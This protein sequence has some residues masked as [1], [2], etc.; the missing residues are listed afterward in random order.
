MEGGGGEKR[1][2][3]EKKERAMLEPDKPFVHQ[4]GLFSLL[5]DK[6]WASFI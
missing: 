5:F 2:M 3:K 4:R 6:H 1:Q